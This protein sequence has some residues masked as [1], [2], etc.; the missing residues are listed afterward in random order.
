MLK[1]CAPIWFGAA[2]SSLAVLVLA[3]PAAAQTYNDPQNRQMANAAP[4]P[5]SYGGGFF[6]FLATGGRSTYN[7][8]ASSTPASAY[9][10]E[11]Q[12]AEPQ[13]TVDPMFLRQ[14][15]DYSGSERPG[16][17]VIDTKDKFLFL[18]EKDGKAR[19]YGVG[20]GREGF[21]WSGTE[22]ISRKAEW[23]DWTPPSEM[24]K[25][26]PDLPTHMAGGIGNPLGARALYLGAS[27]YRIHGTNEPYS[28]G[29]NVS[30]GCI[31]M[32]NED[33]IDLYDRVGVG[34]KV[35]VM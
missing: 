16:T 10:A 13:R 31:R 26:R 28:I 27:L 21:A 1:P 6:E 25:R 18:V 17:I 4:P 8:P 12:P 5:G 15:V 20:V 11:A 34:T 24:L 2:L 19:R 30:S 22:K 35:I 3:L 9:R 29:T 33:V 14:E 23:P 7:T 32:M